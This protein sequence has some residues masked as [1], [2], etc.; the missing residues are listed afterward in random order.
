MNIKNSPLILASE[1]MYVAVIG[2]SQVYKEKAG[3]DLLERIENSPYGSAYNPKAGN[4]KERFLAILPDYD[5]P[6]I[7]GAFMLEGVWSYFVPT[8]FPD[9]TI[10]IEFFVVTEDECRE[11]AENA[12]RGAGLGK[13]AA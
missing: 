1:E 13:R 3:I 2:A 12:A 11:W 6:Q 9:G 4:I 5:L 7:G 10:Q 8:Q